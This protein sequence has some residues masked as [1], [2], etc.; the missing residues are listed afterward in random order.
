MGSANEKQ[1]PT[2]DGGPA[3]PVPEQPAEYTD[4]VQMRGMSLR[5]FFAAA[6]LTGLIATTGMKHAGGDLVSGNEEDENT[7]ANDARCC[8]WGAE[9]NLHAED[10]HR[11]SWLEIIADEAYSFADAMLIEREQR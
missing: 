11:L 3:F 6:A 2:K 9:T 4:G 8:G 10:D 7:I 5:D 1:T